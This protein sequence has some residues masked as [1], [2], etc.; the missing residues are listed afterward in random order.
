MGIN[1]A[2]LDLVSIQLAVLCAESGSLSAAARR[3]N[4]SVSTASLRLSAL[5]AAVAT[6]LFVRN[7]KG[8]RTTSEG[9]LF[10]QH[11]KTILA[12]IALLQ[13]EMGH[14]CAARG[15]GFEV[16]QTSQ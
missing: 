11:A 7:H 8:L 2:R 1:I 14:V 9:G 3:A 13:M 10:V 16:S 5:E 6:Q 4:C 12:Q 15:T